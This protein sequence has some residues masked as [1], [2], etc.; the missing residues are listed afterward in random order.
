M[1]VSLKTLQRVYE[2]RW[3]GRAGQGAKTAAT[4]WA[5]AA[6]DKGYY[7]QAFP[8]YGAERE[9]APVQAFTRISEKPILVHAPVEEPDY[10]IVLD[11]SLLGPIDVVAGLDPQDGVLLINTTRGADEIREKLGGYSG[12]LYLVDATG[13]ALETVKRNVPNV[14]L[15]GALSK[16][17]GLFSLEDIE[18]VVREKLGKKLSQEVVEA[19]IEALRRGYEEFVEG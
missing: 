19:N 6:L 9:G 2:F 4:L 15:T 7:F 17:S 10:V 1:S 8:E 5:L 18:K 13:I 16:I 11:D 14:P 12:K 3:H